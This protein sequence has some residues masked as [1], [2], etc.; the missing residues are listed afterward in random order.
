VQSSGESLP[1]KMPVNRAGS[2]I[3]MDRK[4]NN[5]NECQCFVCYNAAWERMRSY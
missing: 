2:G 4:E 1:A 3:A 5:F